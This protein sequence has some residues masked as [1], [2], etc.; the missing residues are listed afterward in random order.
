M[1]GFRARCAAP[2]DLGRA[3]EHERLRRLRLTE[4]PLFW[5]LPTMRLIGAAAAAG[6]ETINCFGNLSG[7]AGPIVFGWLKDRLHDAAAP[8]LLLALSAS[9]AMALTVA[10]RRASTH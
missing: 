4:L 1:P 7:F 2:D 6:I 8:T 9:A 3:G 5:H 10:Y